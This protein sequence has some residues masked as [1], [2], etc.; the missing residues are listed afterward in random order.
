M[1]RP[2]RGLDVAVVAV[3]GVVV[4][5]PV[6]AQ[7]RTGS[8]GELM[9]TAIKRRVLRVLGEPVRHHGRNLLDVAWSPDGGMVATAA[10]DGSVV[11]WSSKDGKMLRT[12]PQRRDAVTGLTFGAGGRLYTVTR[13]GIRVSLAKTGKTLA[14]WPHKVDGSPTLAVARDRGFLACTH[15]RAKQ[16]V[17]HDL[18]KGTVLH[19]IPFACARIG[20]AAFSSDGRHLFAVG[21]DPHRL[22]AFDLDAGRQV[23]SRELDQSPGPLA[24]SPDGSLLVLGR[25]RRL[26]CYDL[27]AID[28]SRSLDPIDEGIDALAFASDGKSLF[29][30]CSKGSLARLDLAA[31]KLRWRQRRT[32]QVIRRL[33][34][35]P[36]DSVVATIGYHG[37]PLRFWDAKTGAI[38]HPLDGHRTSVG[39]TAWSPD[40]KNLVSGAADGRLLAWDGKSPKPEKLLRQLQAGVRDAVFAARDR[41]WVVDDRAL[42]QIDVGTGTDVSTISMPEDVGSVRVAVVRPD[43]GRAVTAHLRQSLLVW[44]LDGAR[45]V[46]KLRLGGADSNRAGLLALSAA[47]DYLVAAGRDEVVGVFDLGAS[48]L[49][50][51]VKPAKIRSTDLKFIDATRFACISYG[52]TEVSVFD[53]AS[54]AL[55]RRLDTG[56]RRLHAL[57]VSVHGKWL[58]VA[59]G[60]GLR[61]FE[62]K[63]WRLLRETDA[64]EG[65]VHSLRFGPKGKRLALGLRDGRILVL[66]WQRMP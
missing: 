25:G 60:D 61:V 58:A 59:G 17:V 12:L 23:A 26:T 42:V 9:Q 11:V 29:I 43:L 49:L 34:V 35:A 57:G 24:V 55:L 18:Q 19:T 33:A 53:A 2:I 48:K 39:T 51:T 14:T 38:Q 64:F 22:V 54:G 4:A 30:G 20:A 56:D 62:T 3:L 21:R 40:G 13:A 1:L 8:R 45:V 7:K 46:A 52:S 16:L 36:D 66:Q 50:H 5:A 44:D 31:G 27:P 32:Q 6:A 28:V 63:K 37:A 10:D 15:P 41:I 65:T 47:G